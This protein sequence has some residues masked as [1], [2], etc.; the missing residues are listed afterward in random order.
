MT[1]S[2][3]GD[4]YD[5]TSLRLRFAAIVA[6]LGLSLFG[7]LLAIVVTDFGRIR[8]RSESTER[9]LRERTADAVSSQ[10]VRWLEGEVAATIRG[11]ADARRLPVRLGE[12]KC[13]DD[14]AFRRCVEKAVLVRDD[15]GGLPP[16]IYNL[17]PELVFESGD[18]DVARAAALVRESQTMGGVVSD[19]ANRMRL[20]G[21]IRVD[22]KPWGGFYLAAADVSGGVTPGDPFAPAGRVA[23]VAILGTLILAAG[24]YV[25]LARSVIRPLESLAD[26]AGKIAEGDYSQRV[27]DP[28]RT[29]EVGRTIGAVN[30]MLDL[31]EDWRDHMEAR[32]AEKTEEVARKDR[33][34]LNARRLASVGTLG[35]GIA[36]EI[37]NPLGGMMNAVAT[38]KRREI[39]EER[40]EKSMR[41]LE[42]GI[43]RIRDIVRK[44]LD[45]RPRGHGVAPMDAARAVAVAVDLCRW[46]A[47]RAGV[48]LRND[49]PA[50]LPKVMGD[51]GD[52]AQAVLNLLINAVDAS[53]S[54][55]APVVVSASSSESTVTI[56]VEDGGVGMDADILAR[57]LDPFFTTKEPGKGT[58]LGLPLVHGVVTA[59]GGRLSIRS[60]PGVGT[61]VEIVL[62]RVA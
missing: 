47:E 30:R 25:A 20:A 46:R 11:S 44:T 4:F 43:E 9:L 32:V 10:L 33:E 53:E 40:R 56:V 42:D 8:E 51:P 62:A 52:M 27:G 57:A 49:V 36:H 31:V 28:G 16:E 1:T 35:A 17:R 14:P 21:A 55:R 6:V 29:D 2:R 22:G 39:P 18:F 26:V 13:W 5:G 37:N 15:G 24:I 12:L 60:T 34:L 7:L 23:V 41:L 3:A 19:A 48:A 50:D 61:R 58:G 54:T 38:L 59:S 45:L